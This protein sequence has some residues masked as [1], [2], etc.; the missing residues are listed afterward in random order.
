M[1]RHLV[2]ALSL[3]AGFTAADV[4]AQAQFQQHAQQR[5]RPQQA[6]PRLV[7]PVAGPVVQRFGHTDDQGIVSRGQTYEP[8][9]GARV[10][11]PAAGSVMFAGPLGGLGLILIVE[12]AGG[13]HSLV[14]GLVRIDVRVGQRVTQGQAVGQME[15]RGEGRPRLYF[16]FRQAG[17]PVDPQRGLPASDG[18]GQG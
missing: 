3:L 11:A 7:A 18:R 9:R 14:A 1:V 6:F 4:A 13:Y 16:E 15:Q 10:S 8:A 2:L 5:G 17:Q 12:H